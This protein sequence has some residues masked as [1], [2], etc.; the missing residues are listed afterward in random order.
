MWDAAVQGG[1]L[2]GFGSTADVA[3]SRQSLAAVKPNWALRAPRDALYPFVL[4]SSRASR[5]ELPALV[6]DRP[7]RNRQSL[8]A[9][10]PNW[11]PTGPWIDPVGFS[12]QLGLISK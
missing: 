10:K 2:E 8:A 7:G 11:A 5:D 1:L 6:L 3:R 9:V 4:I 12:G